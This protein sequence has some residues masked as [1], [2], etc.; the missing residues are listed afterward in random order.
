MQVDLLTIRM[1]V[2]AA[3]ADLSGRKFGRTALMKFCYFLQVVKKVPLRY[4]F[5][6]Y[7]YGPFDSDVL[8][9]LQTAEE[10]KILEST[11]EHYPGGYGYS[12]GQGVNAKRV[13]KYCSDFLLKHHDAIQWAADTLARRSASELEL[14]STIVFVF[15]EKEAISDSHLITLVRA[16]KPHFSSSEVKKQIEW[17]RDNDLIGTIVEKAMQ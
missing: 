2:F 9:D 4:N 11:V 7:S 5:S 1:G 10:S 14:T 15:R 8:A 13:Q 3:L 12:I 16:I 6:L 17:L